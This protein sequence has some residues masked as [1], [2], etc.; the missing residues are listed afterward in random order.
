MKK[1]ITI[2]DLMIKNE[3]KENPIFVISDLSNIYN[4]LVKSYQELSRKEDELENALAVKDYLYEILHSMDLIN[5]L[6]ISDKSIQEILDERFKF[7]S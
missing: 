2:D 7:S 4:K 5:R 1:Q 6:L 3:I